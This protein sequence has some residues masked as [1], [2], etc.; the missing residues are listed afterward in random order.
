[1][2][3]LDNLEKIIQ[4]ERDHPVETYLAEGVH[5]WPL[6]RNA[7]SWDFYSKKKPDKKSIK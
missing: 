4:Y 5:L 6:L 2:V 7:L 1:M 3:N